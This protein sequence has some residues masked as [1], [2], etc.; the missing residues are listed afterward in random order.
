[1]PEG[2]RLHF[3]SGLGIGLVSKWRQLC[4][5]E[6]PT[7]RL[8]TTASFV[9]MV[10]SV[11][12]LAGHTSPFISSVTFLIANKLIN[13]AAGAL[14]TL[15]V[16]LPPAENINLLL[17][18]GVLEVHN[19]RIS[20]LGSEWLS[21]LWCPLLAGFPGGPRYCFP[22]RRVECLAAENTLSRS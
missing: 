10:G 14:K 2:Q 6:P 20:S 11:P 9:Q 5:W 8:L 18:P 15:V 16:T 19:S 12:A 4:K 17:I 3:C 21:F 13:Y 22:R 7:F 1:M